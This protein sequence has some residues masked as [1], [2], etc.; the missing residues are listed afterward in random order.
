MRYQ[1]GSDQSHLAVVEIIHVEGEES[2]MTIMIFC[3]DVCVCVYVCGEE[4]HAGTLT[5]TSRGQGVYA[6]MLVFKISE[7]CILCL[8]NY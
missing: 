1:Q 7:I 3:L 6:P 2:I 8:N 4:Q 5:Y